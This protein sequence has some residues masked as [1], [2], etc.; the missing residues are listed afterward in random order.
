MKQRLKYME[1]KPAGPPAW[2]W[3]RIVC[4]VI[5]FLIALIVLTV[6][7]R[8]F[9]DQ[10]GA[11]PDQQV[12]DFLVPYINHRNTVIMLCFTFLGSHGFLVPSY[13][14]LFAWF[15]FIRR[16]KWYFIQSVST[17]V[18][19]LLLMFCL[20]FYFD[21]P[22]PPIPLLTHARG[23]SFPSGHAFM[24][25][26]F[27]GLLIC[28]VYRDVKNNWLK[29]ISIGSLIFI[30]LMTGLSRVYLR[31]HYAS[32]V[33]AGYLFGTLSLITLLWLL[34]QIRKCN[35]KGRDGP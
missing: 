1:D 18:I 30:I 13:L 28:V 25:L 7:I 33:M 19:G 21:Q 5:A 6:A 10:R 14:F 35:A 4:M 9:F 3:L 24:S 20:K 17:G 34:G 2:L 29:W 11:N 31:V 32:D 22:R 27:F 15:F 12:F 26:N 8:L 23:L 16:N